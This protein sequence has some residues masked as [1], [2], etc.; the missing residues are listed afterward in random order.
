MEQ[1]FISSVLVY[2]TFSKKYKQIEKYL[3]S[4]THNIVIGKIDDFAE[5]LQEI[6]DKM[7]KECKVSNNNKM[8]VKVTPQLKLL[9]IVV[10][11]KRDSTGFDN[12][13][14]ISYYKVREVLNVK[15]EKELFS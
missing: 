1:Y 5:V 3:Y 6:I 9:C 7:S 12:V 13:A 14:T 4:L 2:N 11:N 8:A 15:E 10:R